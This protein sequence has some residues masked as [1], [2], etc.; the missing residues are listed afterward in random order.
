MKT[1]LQEVVEVLLD[2]HAALLDIEPR[3]VS[4]CMTALR[5][6]S[7]AKALQAELQ[8]EAYSVT[9]YQTLP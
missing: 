7:L 3:R 8:N 4:R 5:A 6:L 1:N 9:H 2:A